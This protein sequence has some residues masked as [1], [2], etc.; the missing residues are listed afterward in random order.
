M[1]DMDEYEYSEMVL[2]SPVTTTIIEYR[3]P[4]ADPTNTFGGTLIGAALTDVLNDG[5]SMVYSFF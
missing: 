1:S 4:S 2:K 5:L 3:L